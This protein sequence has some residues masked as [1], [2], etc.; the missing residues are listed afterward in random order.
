VANA[1]LSTRWSAVVPLATVSVRPRR[2]ALFDMDRTLVNG[3]TAGLYTRYRRHRGDV[4]LGDRSR[5]LW[6]R[7]QFALGL[8]DGP[9]L[10]R[11]VVASFCG[12]EERALKEAF[13]ECFDGYV[14]DRVRPAGR[15]AVERHRAQGDLV[16]IVTG[17][18][19]YATEPLAAELGI[20]RIVCTELEVDEAGRFT[21]RPVEPLCHGAGKLERARQLADQEGFELTNATFYSDSVRDLPLLEVVGFPR[22]VNPDTALQRIARQRGWP[23]EAW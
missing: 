22:I 2:G 10:A 12:G 5:V 19:R 13:K 9:G 16:A 17:A 15:A 1:G 18:T 23:V 8:K 20:D 14:R 6:W 11:D 21:G 3:D 7:M 4:S